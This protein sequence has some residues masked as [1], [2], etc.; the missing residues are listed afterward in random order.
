[1]T[2]TVENLKH[3]I[4]LQLEA[5]LADIEKS[6]IL[7]GTVYQYAVELYVKVEEVV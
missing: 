4:D 3:E 5:M 2:D 1:M 7:R 6:T